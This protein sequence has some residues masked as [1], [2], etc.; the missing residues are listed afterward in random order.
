VDAVFADLI[1]SV[2]RDAGIEHVVLIGDGDVPH[3]ADY[4]ELLE[5]GAP[6]APAEPDETDPVILIYTGGTTGRPKGVLLEHRAEMLNL[7]HAAMAIGLDDDCVYLAY[8][9]EHA[10]F[11]QRAMEYEPAPPYQA[12]V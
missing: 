3:D 9:V 1:D 5:S 8:D 6:V 10:R 7:Y 2:R 4:E 12:E 11:T